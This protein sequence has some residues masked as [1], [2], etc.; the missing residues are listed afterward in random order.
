MKMALENMAIKLNKLHDHSYHTF[1]IYSTQ[2]IDK[3]K[4]NATWNNFNHPEIKRNL[5]GKVVVQ[6]TR[7]NEDKKQYQFDV[8]MSTLELENHIA[9]VG[10]IPECSEYSLGKLIE[11]KASLESKLQGINKA[12]A[13]MSQTFIG[14][15]EICEEIK[16]L[17]EDEK[18]ND[19]E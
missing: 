1:D 16:T 18:P 10:S 19:S 4:S 7:D 2:Y 11:L 17:Q 15:G 5:G 3:N 8:T 14:K 9:Y 6:L 13:L 12:I